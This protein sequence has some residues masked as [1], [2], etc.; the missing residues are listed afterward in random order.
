MPIKCDVNIEPAGQE[1]FHAVDKIVMRHA[2]DI[3]NTIGRF[4][5]EKIYQE[6]LSKRC[7]GSFDVHTEVLI[8]VLHHGF[9]KPYFIDMLIDNGIIYELKTMNKLHS[10]HQKQLINYLL[11][12]EIKH[13]KLINFR[14][15]SVDSRFVSTSLSIKDRRAFQIN[16][17][18][19]QGDDKESQQL[20]QTLCSLLEDWGAFLDITLYTEALLYF[21]KGSESGIKPVNI[22]IDSRVVGIQKMNMIDSQ[23]AWHLSAVRDNK[24]F[25]ETHITRLLNHTSLNK[26]HWIN[27]D[28][29]KITLK[30]INNDSVIK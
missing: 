28:H 19:W 24:N 3:H 4:C 6:E 30:T 27:F 15:E 9:S 25:Y 16:D 7:R 12:T 10:T 29:H 11:L 1:Q 26:I 5:D 23:T 8:K 14:P 18:S 21:T 22:K 2:F 13:G 20:H 17:D